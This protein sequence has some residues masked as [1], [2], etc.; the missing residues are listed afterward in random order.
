[1]NSRLQHID[2]AKGLGILLVV[3]GHNEIVL[4]EKGELF[5]IIYSFHLPLFFFLA[6]LFFKADGKITELIRGKVDSIIKPY[7]VTLI[8]VAAIYIP[9]HHSSAIS[10]FAGMIYGTE[11]TIPAEWA[12]LWFLPHLW[13]IF[14]FSWLLIKVTNLCA[15]D[16]IWRIFMLLFILL[17]GVLSIDLFWEKPINSTGI[18]AKLFSDNS[19]RGL[20]LSLDILLISSF[21][22]LLGFLLKKQVFDVK[23]KYPYLALSLFVFSFYH[24]YFNYTMDLSERRYDNLLISTLEAICGIYIVL[25]FSKL[26]SQYKGISE[27]LSYIGAGSLF[28][29]IF[30][31]FV[32]LK[33]LG[34]LSKIFH[35]CN[36]FNKLGAFVVACVIPLFLWELVKKNDYLAML[37][38]PLKNNKLL[39]K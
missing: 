25:C 19:L 9:L 38:L 13:A 3:F 18:L 31:Q 26:I 32:Q 1:M 34:L 23:V 20:P 8:I 27:I 15:I 36:Y 12:P 35:D 2:I 14:A 5:N 39:K 21:F 22:F 4:N 33:V 24:Y 7:F 16:K 6:A 28:I 29:L 30:H 17:I 10:Y 11:N 37:W